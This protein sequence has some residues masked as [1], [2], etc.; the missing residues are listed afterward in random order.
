MLGSLQSMW[1]LCEVL[2]YI[3]RPGHLQHLPV[4]ADKNKN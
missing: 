1:C 2:Y 3:L 4:Y